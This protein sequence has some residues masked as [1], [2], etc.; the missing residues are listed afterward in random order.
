M[1]D[2]Y[3]AFS[4]EVTKRLPILVES[5][6]SGD[7]AR[8]IGLMADA[9]A[10]DGIIRAFGTGH[11]EAFAMEVAGRAGGLIPTSRLALRDIVLY[12]THEVSELADPTLERDP[13]LSQELFDLHNRHPEDI[14]VIASNSGVNGSIVGV[15]EQVKA[16]GHTLIAVTSLDHTMKVT[17]KHPSGKRLMDFADVTI[18]NL[19][20][21]G[22]STLTLESGLV[23]GAI[24]SITAA[25][26]AQLLTL[27]VAENLSARGIT[28]PVYISA[29]VPGGDEHNNVLKAKYAGRLR[30]DG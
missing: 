18:D 28:P 6:R 16:H 17:S 22:D 26:I 10:K 8:A 7:I 23:M 12:G 19:A 30:V 29:N 13:K 25:F 15:A 27:G 24:S 5:A 3:E 4:D 1:A 2:T 9:V 21:Y 20:P 11:S 14:Y